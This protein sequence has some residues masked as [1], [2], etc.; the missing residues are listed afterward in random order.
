MA[1]DTVSLNHFKF[2]SRVNGRRT[3]GH[4]HRIE[5]REPIGQGQ[6]QPQRFARDEFDLAGHF[7]GAVSGEE[8]D[9]GRRVEPRAVERDRSRHDV[10]VT[11]GSA[12]GI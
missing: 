5:A 8:L 1:A 12:D 6:L 11:G 2:L 10:S 4:T 3:F 9:S 7:H